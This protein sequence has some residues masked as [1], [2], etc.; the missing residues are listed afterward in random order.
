MHYVRICKRENSRSAGRCS[1]EWQKTD[2]EF[3]SVGEMCSRA[4]IARPSAVA[5][6]SASRSNS[7]LEIHLGPSEDVMR[8]ILWRLSVLRVALCAIA[9]T[10]MT[11]SSAGACTLYAS[12][13]GSP[14]NSGTSPSSPLSLLAARN[15]TQPGSVVCLMAGTYYVDTPFEIDRSGTSSNWITYTNYAG[16]VV[17]IVPN[18]GT[19]PLMEVTAGVRYIEINGLQFDGQ[20]TAN[21]AIACI[22]CDHLRMI[23]NQIS[24]MGAAGIA[25]VPDPTTGK[26]PDYITADH[27]LIYHCG[28]NQG[29]SSAISYVQHGW[30]DSYA[31]F[32]SFVTNNIIS[33]MFDN[34]PQNTDGNGIISDNQ[35][36]D[37][38]PPE[39]IAN[40][41]VYQNGRRCISALRATNTWVVNNT[42]Y[43]NNLDR[44]AG[45][46]QTDGASGTYEVNNISYGWSTNSP[47]LDIAPLVDTTYYYNQWI[48]SGTG[49]PS[50]IPTS[51]LS[52]SAALKHADPLFV[53]PPYV[54]PTGSGQYNN[55][56]QPDLI[57]NQFNLQ[58]GS[59]AIGAGID[60]TTIA[61]ISS[62]IISGLKQYVY[63]DIA[64]NSRTPGSHFDL[65]AYAYTTSPSTPSSSTLTP[66]ADTYVD[67]A[68]PNT[69]YGTNAELKVG[70]S[71]S[72]RIIYL[73]CDLSALAGQT[74]SSAHL[75]FWVYNA[76]TGTYSISPVSNTS[77]TNSGLT[78]SNKP[79]Y[80]SVAA[81]VTNP[82]PDTWI[83]FDITSNIANNVG[84]SISFAIT[85]TSSQ[86]LFVDSTR[87]TYMKPQVVITK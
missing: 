15:R 63:T 18:S 45:D 61:G 73:T 4:F 66:V 77:W 55:A 24:H 85:S 9:L 48:S 67:S 11:A 28:Y 30:Y 87:V 1:S 49:T 40:N 26:A 16:A 70:G 32:H 37:V 82:A 14:K 53:N 2:Y 42:C 84:K 3:R 79:S 75:R 6:A 47:Y 52:D 17:M 38:T 59:P 12:P 71:A 29:F 57:S 83:D 34:S 8:A 20:N 74:I 35:P 39:L 78:Y 51:V 69:N 76:A 56:V 25:T 46:F 19:L 64:G 22:G 41:V 36:G 50:V 7:R 43:K 58:A 81:S 44:Y 60:P 72:V 27:N 21:T 31:G 5:G 65:G 80:G 33:G 54:A 62:D 13:S 10:L 68:T 23:S 86:T